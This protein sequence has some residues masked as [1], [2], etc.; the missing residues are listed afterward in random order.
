M[1]KLVFVVEGGAARIRLVETG[2]ASESEIEIT[3]GLRDGETIVEG[4][5]RVLSRDLKDGKPVKE[6]KE[7]ELGERKP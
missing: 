2:L 3:S 6:A 7:G 4:P 1:R 5:Y